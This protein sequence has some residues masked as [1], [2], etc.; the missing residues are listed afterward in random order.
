VFTV[1]EAIDRAQRDADELVEDLCR[2]QKQR[3]LHSGFDAYRTAAENL[4]TK[5]WTRMQPGERV[6]SPADAALLNEVQC[7]LMRWE[8]L[9]KKFRE[10]QAKSAEVSADASE[11]TSGVKSAEYEKRILA[12]FAGANHPLYFNEVLEVA[13]GEPVPPV[14]RQAWDHWRDAFAA[15]YE[16]KLIEALPAA[17]GEVRR[18][19]LT[20]AGR[21]L[22]ELDG[23]DL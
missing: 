17:E 4:V 21:S 11:L 16:R 15:I 2:L 14:P 7:A 19:Q 3:L 5:G 12:V 1:G 8:S 23:V 18:Y 10:N 20:P 13:A 6:I 9:K 22:H